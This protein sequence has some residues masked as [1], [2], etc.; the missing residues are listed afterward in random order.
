MK[1]YGDKHSP[2][3]R[4]DSTV[5]SSYSN[6]SNCRR[7]SLLSS[8]LTASVSL[9]LSEPVSPHQLSLSCL[10]HRFKISLSLPP[11][12]LSAMPIPPS[13]FPYSTISS[14]SAG[15]VPVTLSLTCF[16]SPFSR[17]LC[18]SPTRFFFPSPTRSF[19]LLYPQPSVLLLCPCLLISFCLFSSPPPLSPR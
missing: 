12:A 8:S 2:I 13:P 4:K 3:T 5:P 15:S 11:L 14:S 10:S 17:S 19:L 16:F 18:L 6:N 9:P 1:R 7:S